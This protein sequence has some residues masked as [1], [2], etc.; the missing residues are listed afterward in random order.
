MKR[1]Y[2]VGPSGHV[3]CRVCS[4]TLGSVSGLDDRRGLAAHEIQN[5]ERH[6]KVQRATLA[7]REGMR[8]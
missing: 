5:H 3:F 4:A 7:A 8:P 2:V 6:P 1:T